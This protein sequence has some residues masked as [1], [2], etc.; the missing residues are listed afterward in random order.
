MRCL[1]FAAVGLLLWIGGCASN[2]KSGGSAPP[3]ACHGPGC[4]AATGG[5]ANN[6]PDASS[7]GADTT[8]DVEDA[9]SSWLVA[10]CGAQGGVCAPG[11]ANDGC[12]D[13]DAGTDSTEPPDGGAE[14]T[15][16]IRRASPGSSNIELACEST[17]QIRPGGACVATTDCVAG[18]TC[19]ADPLAPVCRR[20]CCDGPNSCPAGTY[21]TT[22][23]TH[24]TTTQNGNYEAGATV[25]VCLPA[26][27]CNLSEPYPCPADQKCLCTSDEACMIVRA[28]GLTSCVP[29]PKSNAP[30]CRSDTGVSLCS[31]GYVC[32]LTIS[33]C[34]KLCKLGTNKAVDGGDQSGCSAGTSCQ[35]SNDVPSGWGVCGNEPLLID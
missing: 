19:V 16:R 6:K 11:Q 31:P 2:S 13:S 22:R 5:T 30:Q 3:S 25:P 23:N 14:T 17:G 35:A 34:L 7:Q 32:A 29:P 10:T 15:C 1:H 20:Y 27:N 18:S 26:D 24:V 4:A 33:K 9:G 12:E 8:F 21:C 28:G